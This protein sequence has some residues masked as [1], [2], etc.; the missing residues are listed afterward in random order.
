MVVGC[1]RGSSVGDGVIWLIRC[2]DR[3]IDSVFH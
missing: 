2:I 3:C 1:T